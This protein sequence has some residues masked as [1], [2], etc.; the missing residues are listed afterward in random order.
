MSTVQNKESLARTCWWGW[1][2]ARAC[3]T[4]LSWQQVHS[5]AHEHTWVN[6]ARRKL[7]QGF[8][9]QNLATNNANVV[10]RKVARPGVAGAH[11]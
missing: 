4:Y 7:G 9:V 6:E 11:A 3:P 5:R 8:L 10:V 2:L 1:G